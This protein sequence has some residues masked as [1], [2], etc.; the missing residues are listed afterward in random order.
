MSPSHAAE[1]DVAQ[2]LLGAQDVEA[3]LLEDLRSQLEEHVGPCL[4]QTVLQIHFHAV[5]G[6]NLILGAI[7]KVGP[8]K[9][10]I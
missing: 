7:Q 9:K 1:Y 2:L 10:E 8:L 5:G 6:V 3:G 4:F